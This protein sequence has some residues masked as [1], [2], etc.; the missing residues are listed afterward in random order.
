MRSS[1]TWERTSADTPT[2]DGAQ[3]QVA[4]QI[5]QG[6]GLLLTAIIIGL[7][8]GCLLGAQPS[9]N[10]QLGRNVEHPLQATLISFASGTVIVFVLSILSG[11]F[12][13]SFTTPPR[14]LPWWIWFGGAI[15]VVM[16][17]TSLILVP[18]IGS[19]SWF[20]AVMTGQT[21]AAI[22][23]DHYGLLGNPKTVASPLR[24]LG[25]G[26]LVSGVFVIVQAKRIESR[27]G[28]NLM[29]QEVRTSEPADPAN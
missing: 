4:R 24:L 18:R 22:V 13:P 8:A 12:P 21:V 23:L 28:T 20:A 29:E 3:P 1:P 16:V 19:L 11:H 14:E 6:F 10:G 15:G 9:V 7:A 17:T 27:Q 26:L 25:A 5:V 2:D